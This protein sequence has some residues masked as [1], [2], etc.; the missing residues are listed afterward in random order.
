MLGYPKQK[1][2]KRKLKH[3]PSILHPQDGT[4]YLCM[5]LHEDYRQKKG[6]E[7]HHVFPGNFGRRISEENGFKVY[8]CPDHHRNGS[9][10]VHN[11]HDNLLLIQEDAQRE[12][13]KT[14]TREDWMELMRRTYL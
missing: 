3:A 13:E 2:I 1:Q 11:N 14:N 6:L 12:Y 4:C 10:A 5:K 7:E 8:L 9:E